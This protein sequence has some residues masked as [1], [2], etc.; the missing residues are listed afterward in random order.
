MCIPYIIKISYNDIDIY[1]YK[2]IFDQVIVDYIIE[3]K[4]LN[5]NYLND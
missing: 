1:N 4:N 3:E 5:F 2:I